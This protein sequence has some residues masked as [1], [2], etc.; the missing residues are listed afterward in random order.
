MIIE[1]ILKVLFSMIFYR[2]WT[3]VKLIPSGHTRSFDKRKR[4]FKNF[5]TYSVS[6]PFGLLHTLNV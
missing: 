6:V 3:R 5:V 2:S 1:Q 4:K